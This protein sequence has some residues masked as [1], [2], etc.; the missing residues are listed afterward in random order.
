MRMELSKI[1]LSTINSNQM[2]LLISCLLFVFSSSIVAQTFPYKLFDSG[3]VYHQY[4]GFEI[5]EVGGQLYV[6][7]T[8]V[9]TLNNP[10]EKNLLITSFDL[11]FNNQTPFLWN[12]P[13]FINERMLVAQADFHFSDDSDNLIIPYFSTDLG[14]VVTL[15]VK[16]ST[17]YQVISCEEP[18]GIQ[19]TRAFGD[20]VLWPSDSLQL[21]QSTDDLRS[22]FISGI[23][24]E[25]S[26]EFNNHIIT[27][28]L[29][30]RYLPLD[31]HI[32][33]QDTLIVTGR[34][35]NSLAPSREDHELGIFIAK[36]DQNYNLVDCALI[37]EDYNGSSITFEGFLDED[38][39]VIIGCGA[40]DRQ[41]YINTGLTRGYTVILK[42]DPVTSEV[43]WETPL[44]STLF[45]DW[46]SHITSFVDSQMQDGY[47]FV[48]R[49]YETPDG[50][51]SSIVYGKLSKGGEMLWRRE[52][53]DPYLPSSINARDVIA[54]SD[55][56]YV[57][58]GSRS[59]RSESDGFTT[60][61]Q[62]VLMK[63]DEDGNI[64]DLPTS[65]EEVKTSTFTILPNPT[66]NQFILETGL[67]EK[68]LIYI[69][70]MSGQLV[71]TDTCQ[72]A[73]CI[74]GTAE[75]KVGSYVV[76]FSDSS[77]EL[78]GRGSIIIQ[79]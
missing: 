60:L 47:I 28:D 75:L 59:D 58:T 18:Q 13:D 25:G 20:S 68:K 34:Y 64:I 73:D 71:L 46:N 2:K 61:V 9:D 36:I 72:T 31:M 55:G 24:L 38:G 77:G 48:G 50:G 63:F 12:N 4:S 8:A 43:L 10:T 30:Y 26:E 57:L 70:D 78:L 35:S 42:I 51:A 62:L 11:D 39:N 37:G 15:D 56:H 17:T 45:S 54:T 79:R 44:D 21:L 32:L 3:D 67:T 49:G 27:P 65:T 41:D 52:I 76:L 69:T 16:E 6:L 29:P 33:D 53:F 74:V 22:F 19:K 5:K 14:C 66:S 23:S 7:A 40:N 1:E